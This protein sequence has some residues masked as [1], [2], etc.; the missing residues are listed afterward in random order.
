MSNNNNKI[1]MRKGLPGLQRIRVIRGM[2][3]TDLGNAVGCTP[4]LIG[5][6]ELGHY[7]VRS[8]MLRKIRMVLGCSFEA[9]FTD[10]NDK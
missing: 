5:Q 1:S 2:T 9:L 3:Q 10:F 7:D 8:V 4:Q 6:I